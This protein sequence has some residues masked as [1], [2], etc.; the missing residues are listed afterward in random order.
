DLAEQLHEQAQA[1]IHEAEAV[2]A[3]QRQQLEAQLQLAQQALVAAHQQQR[4]QASALA[5][6][7]EKLAATQSTLQREQLRSASLNQSLGELQVRL[8]DKDE[9]VRSLEEKHRHARDAQEQ[10][11][12]GMLARQAELTQ[13]HRD[14]ESL[15]AQTRQQATQRTQLEEQLEQRDAQVQGLRAIL[16]QVQGASEQM[17]RQLE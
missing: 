9:Q 10:L 14:N 2:F 12:Q 3:E 13:L 1:R 5:A 8:A 16:A 15:L 11:Q 4:V 17:R 7:S 6:E